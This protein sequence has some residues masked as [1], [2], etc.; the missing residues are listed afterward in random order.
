MMKTSLIAAAAALA[1]AGCI[2]TTSY[3][4][5]AAPVPASWQD[6]STAAAA[7]PLPWQQFY[8]DAQLRE[9]ITLALQNSR[10]LRV[11]LLNVEQA[12]AQSRVQ[13]ASL[14]PTIGAGVTA[15]RTPGSNGAINNSYQAGLQISAYEVDL[16]G[17]LRSLSGAALERYLASVEGSRAAQISLV[18]QIASTYLS[19]RANEELLSLAEQTLKTRDDFYRLTKL[20]SDNGVASGLDMSA[21]TSQVEVARASLA[22]QQRLRALDLNALQLLVGQALPQLSGGTAW[23]AQAVA[24]VP[25]GLPSEVLVNRPDILQAEAQL[26]AAEANIAAARAAFFPSLTLTTSLGTAS[27][28]LSKLFSNT[29]WSFAPQLLMPI[30][31]SGRNKANLA[32]AQAGRDIAV[33]QYEKAIQVGFR[34][35]ADALAA[36]ATLAEQLRATQAQARADEDR[37]KLVDLRFRAGASNSLELLDAQRSQF[38]ARQAV[39]QLQLARAQNSVSLY[40]ALGGGWTQP[41]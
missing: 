8:T 9:L 35:V 19:L 12:R 38:A 36:R 11:A 24:D 25:A 14:L 21:A 20:K 33:A 27:S 15:S 28:E 5:P 1:L 39:V 6:A 10:D 13:D 22:Q 16:F 26:K 34:E 41:Q 29:V 37:L 17:R 32:S 23:N 4:R 40:K 2:S 7:A 3:E 31:D 30:F 18:A